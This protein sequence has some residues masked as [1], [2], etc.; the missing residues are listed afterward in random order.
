MSEKTR[1]VHEL[2][3]DDD[4]ISAGIPPR[5]KEEFVARTGIDL[6]NAHDTGSTPEQF[7][8]EEALLKQY[9]ADGFRIENYPSSNSPENRKRFYEA[10]EAACQAGKE[11]RIS[12]DQHGMTI[13]IK[14]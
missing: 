10:V 9:R 2:E 6:E 11:V 3:E 1:P 12:G 14:E 5:N 7:E 8:L 13:S 4:V